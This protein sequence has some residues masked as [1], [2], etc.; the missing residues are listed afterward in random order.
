MTFTEDFRGVQ[1]DIMTALG[2][3]AVYTPTGGGTPVNT[4]ALVEHLVGIVGG[5]DFYASASETRTVISL[6]VEDVGIIEA[7][8]Q[9][10]A[11]SI[12]YTVQSLIDNNGI[13][14]RMVADD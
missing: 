6:L 4:L 12:T 8:D 13:V 2:V 11:D 9:I 14:V 7:G 1:R 5:A 3:A 10:T